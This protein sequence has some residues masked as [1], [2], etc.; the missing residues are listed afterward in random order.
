MILHRIS[1]HIKS[2]NWFAVTV[3]FVIVVLGVFMGLQVQ[4]WNEAR[5]ERIE[6]SELLVRLYEETQ[7]LL[8]VQ[9]EEL[10]ELRARSDVLMGANPVLFSQAP[11]R[12]LSGLECE[13]VASS[14]VFRRPPDELPVL[15]EMFATGK[16]DLL[17]DKVVKEQLRSYVLLRG[18]GRA[19]YQEATNELFR[20][21]SRFPDLITI[22][23]VPMEDSYVGRWSRLTGEGFRWDPVCDVEKIRTSKAFLNEY[24]DNLSRI[25]SLIQFTEQRQAHLA[26]LESALSERI[27]FD[28]MARKEN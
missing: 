8:A 15:D 4:D 25:G 26:V 11:A 19:Y 16:F 2:Q 14:H 6:E 7:S 9:N 22:G 13:H 10:L 12:A 21:H 18:R 24:V 5:K 17:R 23:R 1:E 3:E 27:K 20:L 28:S